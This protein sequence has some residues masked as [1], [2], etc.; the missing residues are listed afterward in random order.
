MGHD[1]QRE[2]GAITRQRQNAARSPAGPVYLVVSI[3]D[4]DQ[5]AEEQALSTNID[6]RRMVIAHDSVAEFVRV[7]SFLTYMSSLGRVDGP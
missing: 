1:R 6:S 7:L 4:C 5:D 2:G 3:Y